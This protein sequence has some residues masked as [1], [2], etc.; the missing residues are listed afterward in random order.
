MIHICCCCLLR[1]SAATYMSNNSQNGCVR[2]L[3]P[4]FQQNTQHINGRSAARVRSYLFC[5]PLSMVQGVPLV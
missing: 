3:Q 2:D 4:T 1:I 5:L